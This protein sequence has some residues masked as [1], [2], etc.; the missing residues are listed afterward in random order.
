MASLQGGAGPG[1]PNVLNVGQTVRCATVDNFQGEEAKVIILSLT[2]N[3][4]KGDIGKM[5]PSTG[6]P[7]PPHAVA[8]VQ[9]EVISMTI[10]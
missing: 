9:G 8:R 10:L 3:N 2:R 1:T 6:R 5:I 7:Y 4:H